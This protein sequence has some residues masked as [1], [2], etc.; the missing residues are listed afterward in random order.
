MAKGG[1][2]GALIAIA[3]FDNW[4]FEVDPY[5]W[6][7]QSRR[8]HKKTGDEYWVNEGYWPHPEMAIGKIVRNEI[9]AAGNTT[10]SKCVDRMVQMSRDLTKQLD[11]ARAMHRGVCDDDG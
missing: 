8:F 3:G 1:S 2:T 10:L 6:A 9:A 11:R 5:N 7:L 4:R